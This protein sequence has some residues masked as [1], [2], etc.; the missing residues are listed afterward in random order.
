MSLRTAS[1][2]GLTVGRAG[3]HRVDEVLVVVRAVDQ[4][5]VAGPGLSL[6]SD[7]GSAS[8]PLAPDPDPAL[9]AD[10]LGRVARPA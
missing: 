8:K 3:L 9:G 6:S 4:M 5:H 2:S 1:A 10:E 7:F